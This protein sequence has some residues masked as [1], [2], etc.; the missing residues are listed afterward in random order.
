MDIAF[1][2]KRKP[3]KHFLEEVKID[4]F[5]GSKVLYEFINMG[6]FEKFMGKFVHLKRCTL[7]R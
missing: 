2:G 4:H 5:C 6:S 1:P 3:K 7:E